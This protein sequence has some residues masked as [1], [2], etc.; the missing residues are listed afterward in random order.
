MLSV[1]MKIGKAEMIMID[2]TRSSQASFL[3]MSS[4]ELKIGKAKLARPSWQGCAPS[5][6]SRGI[7]LFRLAYL[8]AMDQLVFFIF[9]FIFIWLPARVWR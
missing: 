8:I 3:D 1:E 6:D 9:I 4:F 5:L 7:N 2:L